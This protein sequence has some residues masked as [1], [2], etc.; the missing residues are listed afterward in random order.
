M[1]VKDRPQID[2][3]PPPPARARWVRRAL[4][5]AAILI[6]TLVLRWWVPPAIARVRLL[7][8]QHRAMS[9]MAPSDRVVYDD[10]PARAAR[11]LFQSAEYSSL[12]CAGAPTV[13]F[14]TPWKNF[15]EL[16]SPPGAKSEGVLFLH[17]RRNGFGESRLVAVLAYAEEWRV[18]SQ[19]TRPMPRL[20]AA[21]FRPGTTFKNPILSHDINP[22]SAPVWMDD[23]HR[24]FRFYA[25]QPDASDASR[26]TVLYD[27]AGAPRVLDGWLLDDDS[28]RLECR[29]GTGN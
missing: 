5:L 20:V 3:A 11:L 15:Y 14:A 22:W 24:P 23:G 2:Y 21:V 9:Y 19:G 7:Y 25:G 29:G 4:V 28:V 26:F 12:P 18:D 27:V 8:W 16:Y 1:T 10:D 13:R 17:E 6:L